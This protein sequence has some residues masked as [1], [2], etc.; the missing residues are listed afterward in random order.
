MQQL[1]RRPVTPTSCQAGRGDGRST[2]SNTAQCDSITFRNA[3]GQV[4]GQLVNGWLVKRVDTRKHQLQIPPAWCC[5][6]VHI[7][8]L[9]RIGGRGVKLIDERGRIWTAPLSRWQRLRTINRGHG[10][11]YVLQLNRWDVEDPTC[12]QMWLFEVAV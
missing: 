7:E 10:E 4:V 9:H 3:L 12:L 1:T 6:V 2:S 11:Q 5:D 8:Q